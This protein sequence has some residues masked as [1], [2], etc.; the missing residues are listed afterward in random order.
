MTASRQGV[1]STKKEQV[2]RV[3]A[4]V[5]VRGE[6]LGGF[7]DDGGREVEVVVGGDGVAVLGDL[8]DLGEGIEG[9]P[10]MKLGVDD[11]E[12]F[13]ARAEL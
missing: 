5:R 3:G 7:D 13:D 4:V 9:A 8:G 10:M 11:G 2:L 12:G 1:E 6:A